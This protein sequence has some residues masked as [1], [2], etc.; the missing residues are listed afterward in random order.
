MDK[1]G[2]ALPMNTVIIT[3]L[4]VL[5]LIV[6]AVFFLSGTE[7]ITKTIKDVFFG[8]TAGTDRV[9]AVQTCKQRC[10]QLQL[11]PEPAKSAYC[12]SSFGIDENNDGEADFVPNSKPKQYYKYYCW[13]EDLGE[14]KSLNVPCTVGEKS[15]AEI[16]S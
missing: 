12:T 2:Q 3:I 6:I 1:R 14:R 5:V 4:V 7:G 11:L 8:T 10:D 13:G 16:C 9:F 15:G